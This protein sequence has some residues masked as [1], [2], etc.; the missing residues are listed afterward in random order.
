[1]GRAHI[2][3]VGTHDGSEEGREH[4][5]LIHVEQLGVHVGEKIRL[6]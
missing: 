5:H 4:T 6:H 3:F 2:Q 1:M